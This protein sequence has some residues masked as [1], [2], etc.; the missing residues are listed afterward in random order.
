MAQ[1]IQPARELPEPLPAR[2]QKAPSASPHASPGLKART[3]LRA[4]TENKV[5]TD[6]SC[7]G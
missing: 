5:C 2:E 3:G 7:A 1:T 4:G 6:P